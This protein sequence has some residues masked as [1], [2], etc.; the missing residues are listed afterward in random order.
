MVGAVGYG[1]MAA[2]WQQIQ[3]TR[4]AASASASVAAPEAQGA[5]PVRTVAAGAVAAPAAALTGAAL[6]GAE[7]PYVPEGYGPV[8][9][10][11]RTR[12]QYPDLGTPLSNALE[13]RLAGLENELEQASIP[14]VE[15]ESPAESVEKAECQ[16]CKNRQY[17]D[18][19]D[20]PGV[21]F[22]TATKLSPDEAATAV[23]SHEQE[24]VVRE[25]AKAQREGRKVV[26]QSVTIHTSVCPECG[27][28]YVSGGVTRTV[29]A[30][31]DKA[32]P[33]DVQG[34]QGPETEQADYEAAG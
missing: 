2:M 7:L 24:H 15:G 34:P 25:R 26:S 6:T 23:R 5:S 21:S 22:K 28:V 19:S 18:G 1:G 13:G 33:K 27:R 14:G 10:A 3:Y 12:V 8:E 4:G 17:Q 31:D 16:T 11:T 32:D 9:L 20:D 29:T 30:P